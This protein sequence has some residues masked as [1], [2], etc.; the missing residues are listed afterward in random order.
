MVYQLDS[1]KKRFLPRIGTELL[2]FTDSLD[3]SVSC[4]SFLR[5]KREK[6]KKRE[7]GSILITH[8]EN[9]TELTISWNL[10]VVFVSLI[11]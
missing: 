10:L 6:V 11:D 5:Y 9:C 7:S 3:P 2:Y 1:G 8:I 4:V